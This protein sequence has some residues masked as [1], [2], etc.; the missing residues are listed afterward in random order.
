MD[1]IGDRGL[2]RRALWLVGLTVGL[3]LSLPAH[4]PT[5]NQLYIYEH[6]N[7]RGAY[8]MWD[9]SRDIP[10]LRLYKTGGS[11]SPSWNDRISSFKLGSRLKVTFYEHVNYQG[12]TLTFEGRA[13]VPSLVAAG[14]NDR[15]SSL[16][17]EVLE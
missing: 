2:W 14:W 1:R 15:I 3:G 9:G 13:D 17:T 12:K 10:D 4:T 7:Y 16:K 8:I 6:V 11:G 5:S